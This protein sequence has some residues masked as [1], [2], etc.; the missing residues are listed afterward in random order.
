MAALWG[1]ISD[2]VQRSWI[3]STGDKGLTVLLQEA[4]HSMG[5][6]PY[7]EAEGLELLHQLNI[8]DFEGQ[9]LK[10]G[11]FK[12]HWCQAH[13]WINTTSRMAAFGTWPDLFAAS[14]RA[15]LQM[16]LLGVLSYAEGTSNKVSNSTELP[17]LYT[18]CS[19]AW[20]HCS[21]WPGSLLHSYVQVPATPSFSYSLLMA[22]FL[23]LVFRSSTMAHTDI[24]GKVTRISQLKCKEAL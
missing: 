19:V 1:P 15:V 23:M 21:S 3:L 17:C 16:L 11:N 18:E 22:V 24:K 8:I 12:L 10:K 14:S 2:T 4:S 20:Q 9:V 6:F 13:T 5:V 7:G